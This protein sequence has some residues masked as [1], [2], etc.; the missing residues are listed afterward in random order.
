MT[1][2]FKFYKEATGEWYVDLPEWEGT[3]GELQMVAGAD[4]FLDILSE[5][6]AEVFVLMSNE[7]FDQASF[8]EMKSLGRIE[9]WEIGEGAWYKLIS[10]AGIEFPDLDMWLCDV[11]KFVFGNFPKRIYFS[12]SA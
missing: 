12:V 2:V 11:T 6:E 8:L 9:G 3:K 4:T 7:H 1:R 5:G 10:Y